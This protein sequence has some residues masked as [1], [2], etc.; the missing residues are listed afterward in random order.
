LK[1]DPF[2]NF[3]FGGFGNNW[4]DRG[5]VKRYREWYSFPGLEL[6]EIGGTN[7]A[8]GM[9]ELNLPPLRFR[10]L[11]VPV[12]YASVARMSV[13]TSAL[14]TNLDDDIRRREVGNIGAQLDIQMQLLSNLRLT[15]SFG[16]ARAFEKDQRGSDEGMISLKVL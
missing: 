13:F 16:Y 1:D 2:A 8:K 5:K 7:F 4:V 11:G 10:R 6:N 3:Y 15:L 12:L 14:A 9:V